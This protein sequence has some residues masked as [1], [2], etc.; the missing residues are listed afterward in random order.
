[1]PGATALLLA[2]SPSTTNDT[3]NYALVVSNSAGVVTSTVAPIV[4]SDYPAPNLTNGLVAYYPCDVVTG[5]SK[6]PDLVSAY[7]MQLYGGM[8]GTNLITGQWGSGLQFHKVPLQYGFRTATPTDLVPVFRRTNCT[9][10]AW[11]KGVS[12]SF[13]AFTSGNSTDNDT[14]LSFGCNFST[15]FSI[16]FR[17][18]G[19]VVLNGWSNTGADVWDDTWHNVVYV[20]HDVGGSLVANIYVDGVLDPIVP[21]PNYQITV[22]GDGFAWLPRPSGSSGAEVALDEMCYWNRPLSPA[23]IAM[24]QTGYI[25]NP[26]SLLPPLAIT[27][28]DADLAAVASGD[29]TKLRWSVPDNIDSATISGVGDVTAMT[30]AGGGVTNT[31]ITPASKTTYTLIVTRGSQAATN[32]VTVG[33]VSGI[34]AGWALVDN[35][36]FYQP[37]SLAANADAPWVEMYSDTAFVVQPTNCNRLAHIAP[38]SGTGGASMLLNGLAITAGQGRT[39]FFRMTTPAANPVAA[40]RQFLGVSDRVA[41]FPY[42]WLNEYNAGP[43]TFPLWDAS[44]WWLGVSTNSGVI[45]SAGVLSTNGPTLL[46][47]NVYKV[48]VD[49]TNVTIVNPVGSRTLAEEDLFSVHIQKEGDPGRTTLFSDVVSDRFLNTLDQYTAHYPDDNINRLVMGINVDTGGAVLFDDIYLS[50]TAILTNEPI[51]VGYAGP[52]PALSIQWT[53]SNWQ[54]TYEG[55]L[56]EA[57]TVNGTYSDVGGASSPYTVTTS[58]TQK[59]YRAV[60]Q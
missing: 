40:L 4:V 11:V 7:N 32:S 54:I 29:S 24:L 42:Q 36:D 21:K 41:S 1:L 13:V 44:S 34:A 56:Q 52:A 6:T 19:N 12:G 50:K 9:I 35:F 2:F 15:K 27:S 28:F 47:D 33:V 48:W 25:T 37:G 26:P 49:I 43:L 55:K 18:D 23:E 17:T 14:Q 30:L 10:S 22:N 38:S 53:G 51:A 5:T 39:L 16:Y 59:Y 58:G 57:S 20:Q 45:D 8:T 46:A 31:S 3:A 60:C